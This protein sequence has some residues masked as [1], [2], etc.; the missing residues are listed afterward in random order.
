MNRAK[1][2]L[3]ATSPSQPPFRGEL[4]YLPTLL[5]QAPGAPSHVR[6]G[7]APAAHFRAS[8][9]HTLALAPLLCA[10]KPLSA[11]G[12]SGFGY[13]RSFG[14]ASAKIPVESKT[15]DIPEQGRKGNLSNLGFRA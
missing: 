15:P 9:G 2:C 8:P 10:A 13:G 5:S 1:P 6:M 4:F 3:R 12:T 14:R 11:H 7:K